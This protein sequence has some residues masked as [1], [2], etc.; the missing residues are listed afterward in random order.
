MPPRSER[1]LEEVSEADADA[2]AAGGGG[3][4]GGADRLVAD[5]LLIFDGG[6]NCGKDGQMVPVGFGL[7]TVKAGSISIGGRKS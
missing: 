1:Q 6:G 7:P 4:S 5:D 2:E 3:V